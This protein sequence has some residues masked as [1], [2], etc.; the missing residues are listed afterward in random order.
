MRPPVNSTISALE[1]GG[2]VVERT[3]DG[4]L[5]R[6]PPTSGQ[7]YANAQLY[8]YAALRRAAYPNRPPLCLSLR[9]RF[10]SEGAALRGTAGFGF[11]NQPFMPSQR[12]PRLPRYAWFF[13]GAPPHNMPLALGVRGDGFKAA[14]GDF[15]RPAFLALAPFAPLGFMLMRAPALYRRLWPI[16]QRA[17]GVAEAPLQVALTEWHTYRLEWL[18]HSVRFYV[19]DALVLATPRAPRP[20]LGFIAWIDN[21][22]A[23][24]T[25][26]GDLRSGIVPIQQAQWLEIAA[27]S[28]APLTTPHRVDR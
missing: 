15:S 22:Y 3:A 19:D 27:L 24:I 13:F 14:V 25:P 26:Q 10:S 9:A 16:A 8:D 28:I 5:L 23:I 20:P 2:G 1:I 6:L 12:L 4:T 17:I 18:P 11:W 7:V 21:Q